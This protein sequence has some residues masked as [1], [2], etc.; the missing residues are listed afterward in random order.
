M[1]KKLPKINLKKK[2][3]SNPATK[4]QKKKLIK[5]VKNAKNSKNES[6][7]TTKPQKE[8]K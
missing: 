7:T 6:E 2:L 8:N 5:K 3:N 4:E 1:E